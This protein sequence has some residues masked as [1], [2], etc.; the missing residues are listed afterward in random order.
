M[1]LKGNGGQE[2]EGE[3]RHD[4]RVASSPFP[5]QEGKRDWMHTRLKH[6]GSAAEG[7]RS[8][9][10]EWCFQVS[11]HAAQLSDPVQMAQSGRGLCGESLN[12]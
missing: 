9:G 10:G 12:P 8:G 6:H 11:G 3:E 1:I 5:Y 4:I 2:Q 7:V